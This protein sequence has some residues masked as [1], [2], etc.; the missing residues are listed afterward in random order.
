M[1]QK[2]INWQIFS[3]KIFKEKSIN[4]P[5]YETNIKS[6]PFETDEL[7]TLKFNQGFL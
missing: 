7:E 3:P 6:E 2:K 4:R 5:H 1:N